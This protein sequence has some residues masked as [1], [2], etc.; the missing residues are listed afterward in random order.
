MRNFAG[1]SFWR[2]DIQ[3]HD[4]QYNDIQPNDTRYNDIQPNDIQHNN[5]MKRDTQHIGAQ[6]RILGW[7][8]FIL[9]VI[10]GEGYK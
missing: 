7:V 8:L 5:E 6:F 10:C 3:P 4:T 1:D 2:H 9:G